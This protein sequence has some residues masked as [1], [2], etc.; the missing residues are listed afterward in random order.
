MNKYVDENEVKA[1]GELLGKIR[2]KP[3]NA[4]ISIFIFALILL[5]LRTTAAYI[6]CAILILLVIA[7]IIFIKDR[8][9]LDVFDDCLVLHDEKDDR[10]VILIPI[11]KITRWE[12]ARNSSFTTSIYTDDP[13]LPVIN[14]DCFATGKVHYL[15]RKVADDKQSINIGAD[16]RKKR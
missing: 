9:I 4:F 7:G 12:I 11:E 13:E 3:Y 16:I 15:L 6:I 14:F 1:D 5:L 10:K 8:V 2:Y